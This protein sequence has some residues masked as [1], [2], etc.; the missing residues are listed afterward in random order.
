VSGELFFYIKFWVRTGG[1]PGKSADFNPY[2]P[3]YDPHP[4]GSTTPS[5]LDKL[6][7]GDLKPLRSDPPYPA[8]LGTTP[9]KLDK[10]PL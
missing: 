3:H 9:S 2:D 8:T 1:E 7:L 5:K 10:L 6:P 4:A